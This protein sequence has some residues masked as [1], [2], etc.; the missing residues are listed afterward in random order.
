MQFP[1]RLSRIVADIL[2]ILCV[3]QLAKHIPILC[4]NGK[5]GDYSTLQLCVYSRS[6]ARR[7]SSVT[8]SVQGTRYCG[9]WTSH[10]KYVTEVKK[11]GKIGKWVI[12]F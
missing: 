5:I 1:I 4:F 10:W 9:I 3:K 2:M 11:W 6:L 8:Q 7:L 12:R